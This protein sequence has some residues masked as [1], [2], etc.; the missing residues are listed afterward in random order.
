MLV[1][2]FICHDLSSEREVLAQSRLLEE[3]LTRM[4]KLFAI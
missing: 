1:S 2:E 3:S 4:P